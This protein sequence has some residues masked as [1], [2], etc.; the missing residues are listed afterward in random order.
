MSQEDLQTQTFENYLATRDLEQFPVSEFEQLE[1]I[2]EFMP[3]VRAARQYLED[4]NKDLGVSMKHCNLVAHGVVSHL[5]T[6]DKN[7][8]RYLAAFLMPP[9]VSP[10]QMSVLVDPET[11]TTQS[12][13]ASWEAMHTKRNEAEVERLKN[14]IIK[15]PGQVIRIE[16]CMFS[17]KTH[18]LLTL[19]NEVSTYQINGHPYNEVHAFIFAG[20][21][22]TKITTRVGGVGRASA[23]QITYTRDAEPVWF[24]GLV[25]KLEQIERRKGVIIVMDEYTFGEKNPEKIEKLG[26][27]LNDLA[28]SGVTVIMGGLNAN[29]KNESLP[30]SQV[31]DNLAPYLP[32]FL[33]KIVCGSYTFD[34]SS[35]NNITKVGVTISSDTT[36]RH[37][38]VS[39]FADMYYQV[40]IG[41]EEGAGKVEYQTAPAKA[42][43][44]ESLKNNDRYLYD[45]LNSIDD[46]DRE[47]ALVKRMELQVAEA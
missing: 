6:L 24:D 23:V 34:P 33:P 14:I 26:N 44:F 28:Q 15:N 39:G 16:G 7:N 41:R 35:I 21:K 11:M 19:L 8:E 1:T 22:E 12:A 30:I 45:L 17:A 37:D 40:V 5:L 13:L 43:V 38:V 32:S 20:L 2:E 29:F 42:N 36:I 3:V 18:M 10:D 47:A 27:L 31:L 46:E 25:E 4:L 9:V